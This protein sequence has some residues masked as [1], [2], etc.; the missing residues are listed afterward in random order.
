MMLPM[1]SSANG[2]RIASVLAKRENVERKIF[3]MGDSVISAVSGQ[4]VP[5]GYYNAQVML[6]NPIKRGTVVGVCGIGSRGSRACKQSH[7][8]AFRERAANAK[9]ADWTNWRGDR[10]TDS[11]SFQKRTYLQRSPKR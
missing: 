2:L 6:S 9:R 7:Q 3:L 4:K 1:A 11:D 10:K 8:R 5:A